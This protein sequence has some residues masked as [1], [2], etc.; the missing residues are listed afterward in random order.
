MNGK[1]Y[2][3]ANRID[4]GIQNSVINTQRNQN[5][6]ESSDSNQEQNNQQSFNFPNININI[7]N[8]QN[9]GNFNF[10]GKDFILI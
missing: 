4:N 1:N 9:F 7:K 10:G 6:Y 3:L 2:S 8:L 5:H